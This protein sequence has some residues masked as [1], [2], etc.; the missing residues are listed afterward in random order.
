MVPTR[1]CRIWSKQRR[2]EWCEM[3]GW[4]RLCLRNAEINSTYYSTKYFPFRSKIQ[5]KIECTIHFYSDRNDFHSEVNEFVLPSFVTVQYENKKKHSKRSASF[6][7][8]FLKIS[9]PEKLKK[10]KYDFCKQFGIFHFS[11]LQLKTSQ[12]KTVQVQT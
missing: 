2:L 9:A 4:N 3:F 12:A 6:S 7:T 8:L 5:F 10:F 1:L 11:S